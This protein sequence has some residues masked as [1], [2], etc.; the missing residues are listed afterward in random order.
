MVALSL[1]L[2]GTGIG[3]LAGAWVRVPGLVFVILTALVV[4]CASC[5]A[6]DVH[7][8]AATGY[9]VL[10]I[11]T[12]QLGYAAVVLTPLGGDADRKARRREQVRS[13]VRVVRRSVPSQRG[14]AGRQNM[15]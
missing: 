6:F 14:E 12:I 3:L 4:V 8:A 10:S 5:L 1:G 15:E 7:F 13:V 9:L 2:V 11:V